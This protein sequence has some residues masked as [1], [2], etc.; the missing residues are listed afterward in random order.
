MFYGTNEVA[1]AVQLIPEHC[2]EQCNGKCAR[3]GAEF[4]GTCKKFREASSHKCIKECSTGTYHNM[5]MCQVCP[6][7]CE[8]CV[9]ALE[10]IKCREG[11]VRLET[12]DCASECPNSSYAAAN[13]YCIHCHHSCLSCNGPTENNCTACL[14]QLNLRE[15]GTCSVHSPSSCRDGTYFDHRKLECDSCYVTCAK[16]S[17]KES[18]QCTHCKDPYML[19]E[20]GRCVDIR[21]LWSCDSGHYYNF[22]ASS[23]VPCPFMCANCSEDAKC[24]SCAGE[25]YLASDGTCVEICPEHTVADNQDNQ[26]VSCSKNMMLFEGSCINKCPNATYETKNICNHCHRSCAECTGPDA[27]ECLSCPGGTYLQANHCVKVCP[28]GMFSDSRGMCLACPENCANC[29]E[30]TTCSDGH[31]LLITNGSCVNKCPPGFATESSTYT[32][33]PCLPNCIKCSDPRSCQMCADSFSYYKLDQSCVTQCPDGFFTDS[34]STCSPCKSPCSTCLDSPSNCLTCKQNFAMNLT[35]KTC[36]RCCNTNID[37]LCC[38]CNFSN[39]LCVWVN[40]LPTSSYNFDSK[41]G[42][43]GQAV[44]LSVK[45]ALIATIIL[46]LLM[47]LVIALMIGIRCNCTRTAGKMP[48]LKLLALNHS[49]KYTILS[50]KDDSHLK[51]QDNI[52][53][54]SEMKTSL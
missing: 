31:F 18:T 37:S 46:L 32:C 35:S 51:L 7:F 23:C 49:H 41:E 17:G 48:N 44:G 53:S 16:C 27:N 13:G 43:P 42:T 45:G 20:D 1:A 40:L 9:D 12:G 4:C 15:D 52:L 26:C 38:D 24:L 10:C 25:Y 2:D 11:A 21:Q 28:L 5:H 3:T 19:T 30:C 54:K 36:E 29:S 8:E 34:E 22:S 50:E 14:G 39:N 6:E 33:H 47:I